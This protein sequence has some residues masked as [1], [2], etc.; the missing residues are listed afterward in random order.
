MF[1]SI[2]FYIY[3]KIGYVIFNITT[4][5]YVIRRDPNKE[6]KPGSNNFE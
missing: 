1:R 5:L 3:M 4:C 2:N 6:D